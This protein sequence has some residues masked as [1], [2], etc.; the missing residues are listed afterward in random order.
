MAAPARHYVTIRA[1]EDAVTPRVLIRGEGVAA[2]CCE[3]LLRRAGLALIVETAERPKVPAI[4]LGEA[5]QKL[6]ADVFDRQDLF[7]SLPRINKRVVAWGMNS[8]PIALPHS[9]IVAP[10]E[11]LL[12]RIL[13]GLPRC[14]SAVGP[15]AAWTIFASR[16]LPRSLE[17][18]HF[19]SRIATAS[20]VKLKSGYDPGA[21]WI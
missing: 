8:K 18:H 3:H 20:A 19:G 13:S 6:L 21:C 5:T 14:D 4:M 1:H 7:D 16:P 2:C 15:E 9:A 17:E 12:Q 10:E 11:L